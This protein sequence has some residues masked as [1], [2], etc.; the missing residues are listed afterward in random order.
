MPL[1]RIY[2]TLS[3]HFSLSFHRLW[4]V[5][6]GYIS[7][8]HIAAECKFV[9]VVPVFCLAHM[10]GVHRNYVH[11][12]ARPLLLQQCPACPGSST[13][14]SFSWSYF[15]KPLRSGRIWTQGQFLKRSLRGFE[16]QSFPSPRTSC[17]TKAE[18]PSLSFYLP[19]AG[20]RIIGFIPFPRV[21]V[22][23]EMQSVSSRIWT[24]ITVSISCDDNHD[25]TGTGSFRDGKQ[26]AVELVPCRVLPPGLVQYCSQYSCVI[27]V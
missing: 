25:T 19:I 5:F 10:R 22:L 27:G 12:W 24:R 20:G 16:F 13:L 15:T 18:K 26:V 23:C 9:L 4:Q 11:L 8:P 17:L 2:L 14:G 6:R 1:A 7:Y 3:L 21:L